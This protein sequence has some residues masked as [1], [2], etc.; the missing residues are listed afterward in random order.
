M[1]LLSCAYRPAR[2][3][4]QARRQ[5]E[6]QGEHVPRDLVPRYIVRGHRPVDDGVVV[7]LGEP[8][9]VDDVVARLVQHGDADVA[10]E[11]SL[12]LEHPAP[13]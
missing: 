13:A 2:S 4:A 11:L 12:V 5:V 10:R 6:G 3:F 9:A 1:A 7:A 8:C